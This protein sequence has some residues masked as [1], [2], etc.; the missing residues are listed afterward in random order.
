MSEAHG[1]YQPIQELRAAEKNARFGILG[2][3]L[4]IAAALLVLKLIG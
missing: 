3:V 4:L 2:F 1:S